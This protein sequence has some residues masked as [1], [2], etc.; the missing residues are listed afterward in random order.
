M[1]TGDYLAQ[2]FELFASSVGH[3]TR[4][5][6]DIAAR[7]RQARDDAGADWIA[8]RREHDRND[9]RCLFCRKGWWSV[10][11]KDDIDVHPNEIVCEPGQ[12]LVASFGPTVFDRKIA[13]FDPAQ[14]AHSLHKCGSPCAL[15]RRCTRA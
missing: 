7:S 10:V 6:R 13:A 3:L 11:S 1:Q 14:F 4:Q 12:T 8:S 5:S 2:E 9:R 15:C